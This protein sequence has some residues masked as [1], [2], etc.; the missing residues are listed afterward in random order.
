M[1]ET[2]GGHGL[3]V[4]NAKRSVLIVAGCIALSISLRTQNFFEAKTEHDGKVFSNDANDSVIKTNGKEQSEATFHDIESSVVSSDIGNTP[5]MF[6]SGF[7]SSNDYFTVDQV[8]NMASV[9]TS[10]T[11]VFVGEN[12]ILIQS[13]F[14]DEIIALRSMGETDAGRLSTSGDGTDLENLAF[15]AA[16]DHEA[17]T[18]GDKIIVT[19]ATGAAGNSI[20]TSEI[21]VMVDDAVGERAPGDVEGTVLWFRADRGAYSDTAKTTA[22]V[23]GAAVAYWGDQSGNGY[24]AYHPDPG[25]EPIFTSKSINGNPA[26]TFDRSEEDYLP[27]SGLNYDSSNVPSAI[28]MFA[29]LRTT[30]DFPGIILSYDA[31]EYFRFSANL[32]LN[33]NSVTNGSYGL[34]TNGHF[35]NG[36]SE[37]SNGIP[38]LLSAS[39]DTT[40]S[41][42]DNK[43]LYFNG[44]ADTSTTVNNPSFGDTVRYGYIGVGSEADIFDGITSSNSSIKLTKTGRSPLHYFDGDMAEIIYYERVL[45]ES[46]RQRV[47]SYLAIKYGITLHASVSYLNSDGTVIWDANA[48]AAYSHDI[49]GIGRDDQSALGQRASMSVN[50]DAMVRIESD[51]FS[52]DLAFI[53]WGNNDGSS[54]FG[55]SDV[56]AATYGSRLSRVWKA[57]VAGAPG[58]VEVTMT[59]PGNTGASS[60][61]V[62][63][64]DNDSVFSAGAVNSYTSSGINGDKVF[65]SDVTFSDSNYFTVAQVDAFVTRWT[66]EAEDLTVTIPTTGSGYNYDVS[67]GDGTMET[68]VTGNASHSYDAAGIY[69]I[70]ITGA[71]PRI[72]F[73]DSGDKDKLVSIDQW[74]DIAWTSMMN[75]FYGC[76][77]VTSTATDA[78]NL[79]GVTRT[80]GMFRGASSFNGNVST[81]EVSS[82]I[83]MDWMFASAGNFNQDLSRW[84]I[85]NVT[86]MGNM[87]N[88]A[89]NFN[90]DVSSWKVDKVTNMSWMFALA[91]SFNQDLSN[92]DVSCVKNMNWMFASATS[93]NGDVSSW[94][95]D[96]VTNMNSMFAS[97]SS[98]N[99]DLN[100]WKVSSVKN[101]MASMFEGAHSFNGEVSNWDVS[102]VTNMRDMFKGA[103]MFDH[104]LGAWDISQVT[105]MAG[106]LDGTGLSIPNYD[107]S[108]L[109]W[110]N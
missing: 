76:S 46:E 50:A 58:S 7:F 22:A 72:Y 84:D 98:F 11:P 91:S 103:S 95:V 25:N 102:S 12:T 2:R 88:G 38:H 78:P 37:E 85:S 55:N 30:S 107:A 34:A 62:L 104:S 106:M 40:I 108:L 71:F 100:K 64:V 51:S 53:M 15:S 63:L 101:G 66:V 54:T 42:S 92:W 5:L 105:T 59:I 49:A 8:D 14:S 39:Y 77:K 13:I 20:T 89:S 68:G 31:S 35:Q 110:S 80:S 16:P 83:H 61:Y 28:S 93:F 65:F 36:A 44:L 19:A 87:F 81:W 82:L 74:G 27:I 21:I 17:S 67:W 69:T 9:L 94:E 57:A 96:K 109:G 33:I 3:A 26:L 41:G 90:G 52:N 18:F 79:S 4:R 86:N 29:V 60:Q 47:A 56:D 99:Q 1:K 48:N 43:Y 97:A 24:H 73:N 70:S 75:A 32:K 10:N 23:N 45:S 6:N